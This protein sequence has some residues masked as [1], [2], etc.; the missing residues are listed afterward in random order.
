M[1]K[2]NDYFGK[3]AGLL[4][5]G[6]VVGLLGSCAARGG[7]PSY[8]ELE[9]SQEITWPEPAVESFSLENGIRLFL[10]EDH[11]LPLMKM[12][13]QVKAGE[14]QVPLG[15]AGL[16]EIVAKV[17]RSGGSKEHPSET[18]NLLLENRAAECDLSMDFAAGELTLN[19]LKQDFADLLPAVVQLM[20][21]PALPEDKLTLAKQQLKTSIRRRKDQQQQ[22][23]LIQF[24]RLVYGQDS[25]Y[26]SVPEFDTVDHIALEDVRSFQD[27][28][29]Q[30]KGILVGLVGDFDAAQIKPILRRV[31]STIPEGPE[32]DL[33]FPEIHGAVARKLH[34]VPKSDINQSFIL[35]GHL[36]DYRDNPDYAALQVMNTILSGGFSGRLFEVVRTKEGLAYS[37]SGS[38][39]CNYFYPGL[40]YVALQTKSERTAEAIRVVKRELEKLRSE[41]VTQEELNQAR[42]QF[43]NSLVFRFD[44]PE[45]I[46]ERKLFY[47]YRGMELDSF[48]KLIEQL[49][50]VAVEDVNRVARDYIKLENI[51]TVVV[52]READVLEQLQSLGDVTVVR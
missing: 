10:L 36:G 8:R 12:I 22:M 43:L 24:K 47:A 48:Q 27:Q 37:V 44:K 32:P 9:F 41:G 51:E 13:V 20:M 11:K 26:A 5:A 25:V 34:L 40:F 6:F 38:Y 31:F 19:T 52:G 42:R 1:E 28:A 46:L 29:F 14:F 2:M 49:K 3:A 33:S 35:L 39:G 23:G 16:A 45:E 30:G 17:V 21:N 7:P 50:N 4:A 15:K 18:F